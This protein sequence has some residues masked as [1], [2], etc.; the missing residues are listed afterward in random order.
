MTHSNNLTF[1]NQ[2][3]ITDSITEIS[4]NTNDKIKLIQSIDYIIDLEDLPEMNEENYFEKT[5]TVIYTLRL[6]SLWPIASVWG[7]TAL[8]TGSV[9]GAGADPQ[10][11][12]M[13][14]S[15]LI[16]LVLRIQIYNNFQ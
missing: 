2:E 3:N 14:S 13:G 7:K 10:T 11:W 15:F 9:V 12:K 5:G 6:K 16:S 1:E 4:V 8:N